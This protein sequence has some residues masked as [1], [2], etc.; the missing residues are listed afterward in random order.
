MIFSDPTY[1]LQVL[2]EKTPLVLT[3]NL[4]ITNTE[5]VSIEENVFVF[6][7][8]QEAT[9]LRFGENQAYRFFSEI[10][11]IAQKHV[12]SLF[13]NVDLT[14]ADAWGLTRWLIY[15]GIAQTLGEEM[16]ITTS[17]EKAFEEVF[18]PPDKGGEIIVAAVMDFAWLFYGGYYCGQELTR[19]FSLHPLIQKVLCLAFCNPNTLEQQ[20]LIKTV[21]SELAGIMKGK[22]VLS[23]LHTSEHESE[24]NSRIDEA[25]TLTLHDL[26]KQFEAKPSDIFSQITDTLNGTKNSLL[27]LPNKIDKRFINLVKKECTCGRHWA[28]PGSKDKTQMIWLDSE[29]QDGGQT[30]LDRLMKE[31]L[32]KFA[33]YQP[34]STEPIAPYV[35]ILKGK[36]GTAATQTIFTMCEL[37]QKKGEKPTNA[38]I[39]KHRNVSIKQIEKD[40]RKFKESDP[41]IIAVVRKIIKNFDLR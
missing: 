41:E 27:Y 34:E 11:N 37:M 18:F 14:Q 36:V 33:V 8:F 3:E 15:A 23:E 7:C 24:K 5:M 38:E 13:T 26:R 10:E 6:R 16:Q 35:E 21:H 2:Q 1:I 12:A 25:L 20:E 22:F 19:R 40:K 28:R 30:E 29:T 31:H 17:D 4:I 32:D 9:R 39:A